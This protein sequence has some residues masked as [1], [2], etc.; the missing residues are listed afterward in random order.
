MKTLILLFTLTITIT[1]SPENSVD[2]T[3]NGPVAIIC[4]TNS[5]ANVKLA[6]KEIRRYVYLRTGLV[7]P[8]TE[9]AHGQIIVLKT[10]NSL[11][12]QEYRLQTEGNT[13]TIAG[14]SDVSVLY[15]AYRFIEHLGVRFYLHGDV[16]P[17]EQLQDWQLPKLNE[18][19]KPF[20]STRGIQPFHDFAEGPDWWNQDDYL[21]YVAQLAK[22]RMNFLGLHTYPQG[23]VGPEP[24]VWIGLPQ[25]V[26]PDGTVKFSYWS[27]WHSTARQ[28]TWGYASMKTSDFIGGAA[29]LFPRDDY[30][31]DVM[32]GL[33]PK[34][35]SVEQ[36]NE[37]FNRVG[38]QMYVVFTEAKKLGVKTCIGTETPIT[39]P[40]ALSERL[41]RLGKDPEDSKVVRE[42]YTGMFKRIMAAMPA[43]Y[44]WLWTPEEWTW[45]G[46]KPEQFEA[47][48]KDILTAYEVL[49]DQGKSMQLATSGWVL[50][51]QHDRA[52]LD[53]F[54]SKDC[55][56]SC[57]NREVGHSSVE[58]AFANLKDRPKWS[59]PWMENDPNLV[60]YQP[61]VGRM[62][63]DA[64]DA[65]RLGC[66]GLIGIHWRTKILAMNVA[67]LAQAAWDQSYVPIGF[68]T[69]PI[70]PFDV[71]SESKGQTAVFNTPI[72]GASPKEQSVYQSV[73]YDMSSCTLPILN[74]TYMVTLKF[75]EPHYTA[76]GQR[77]FDVKVQG[78]QVASNLDIFALVGKNKAH[79]IKVSTVVVTD[80]ILK[81]DFI[82][83]EG[84]SLIAGIVVEGM[85]AVVNQ[86]EAQSYSRSVNCG[87]KEGNGYEADAFDGTKNPAPDDRTMPTEAFYTDFAGAHFGN[88]VAKEAGALLSSLDGFGFRS[89]P[90]DWHNGPGN[91]N[92]NSAF[93]QQA[94]EKGG[95]VEK[96]AA[97]HTRVKSAGNLARFDYWLNTLRASV[98]LYEI[99]G[100]RGDLSNVLRQA[101][102]EKDVMKKGEL[103]EKALKYREE[104]SRTWEKLIQL[105]VCAAD[106][107]GELGTI[108]NLEQH[109]RMGA[110]AVT[111]FDKAL[112]DTL[113]ITLPSTCELSKN[114]VGQARI[115][116]PTV[117]SSIAKEESLTLKI[118]A[119]DKQ[120][121]KS[122]AVRIRRYGGGPWQTVTTT[123][124]ARAVYQSILPSALDDFEYYVESTLADGR[125][126]VWPAMAPRMNQTVIV[127]N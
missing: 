116:V 74:G 111:S 93:R 56:M 92:T 60:S 61:W 89:N 57:I 21:A 16:I 68:D 38:K 26:N 18:T 62:R 81:I 121:V 108:A 20:F 84:E 123:H 95:I 33:M 59:I 119:I 52:A 112:T 45:G 64:V 2:S 58:Y 47:T 115:I 8:I 122:V 82:R 94:K 114:Y 5:S 113:G 11:E 46:N 25:D 4:P 127:Q 30:G 69:S 65:R 91:I 98:V 51:P 76:S 43:D 15:G 66:D 10:D 39:I 36:C 9:S 102:S 6:A 120:P 78:K 79:D 118:I 44:Y 85:T 53:A 24:L 22:M 7:L 124:L 73:R 117:R 105:E 86:M 37:L 97:L 54:L 34:P 110:E 71:K 41:K 42:L 88:V 55:P 48:K 1:A 32:K 28:G 17:D 104:L 109:S 80:G 87:G 13:L 67:A 75:C 35:T 125:K 101:V 99:A 77:I 19:A 29:Q 31:P 27:Y 100:I 126:L 49:K 83:K 96:F 103:A 3:D 90:T 14:G 70:K 107:P 23:G 72:A 50:G 12:S 106:T 40:D 63:Y